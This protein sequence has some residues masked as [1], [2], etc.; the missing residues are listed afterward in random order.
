MNNYLGIQKYQ[1]NAKPAPSKP[2]KSKSK[3]LAANNKSDKLDIKLASSEA[4]EQELA[5]IYYSDADKPAIKI[6]MSRVKKVKKINQ[7]AF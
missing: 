1:Q 3:L 7:A 6:D 5:E 4:I 2:K